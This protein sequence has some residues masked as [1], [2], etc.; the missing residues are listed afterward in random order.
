MTHMDNDHRS[1]VA[2]KLYE[3]VLHRAMTW[4]MNQYQ[5]L[6][7]GVRRFSVPYD[8]G[9]EGTVYSALFRADVA[10]GGRRPCGGFGAYAGVA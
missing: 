5:S 2:Q 4:F 6:I 1:A 8:L 3:G 9:S 10:D 7:Y